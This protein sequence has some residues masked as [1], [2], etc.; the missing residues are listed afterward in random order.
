[1]QV[2]NECASVL[3]GKL[4]LE[5]DAIAE[6]ISEL[7]AAPDPVPPIDNGA[8]EAAVVLAG[9]HGLSFYEALIS[10]S[11]L[12]AGCDTLFTE[13]MQDNQR[14]AGLTIVKPFA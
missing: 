3:H 8:Y 12:Q 9:S 11:T 1:M 4:G 14:I 13:D 2:P 10:V 6:A 7:R 5:W